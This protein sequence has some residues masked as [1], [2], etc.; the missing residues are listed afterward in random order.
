[1]AF[2]RFLWT[3]PDK[4]E[5]LFNNYLT[6]RFSIDILNTFNYEEKS[7]MIHQRHT[8]KQFDSYKAVAKNVVVAAAPKQKK[9][10]KYILMRDG[11]MF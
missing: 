2:A 9:A 11:A 8:N 10:K 6:S 7:M 1:L 3:K 4:I 5:K